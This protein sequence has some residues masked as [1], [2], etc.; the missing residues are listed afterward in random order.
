[1]EIDTLFEQL[2]EE[3][4]KAKER[5]LSGEKKRVYAILNTEIEKA[6]A[7]FLI[8]ASDTPGLLLEVNE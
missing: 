2:L 1:M 6:H 7:F 3:I 4:E 8:Y 5:A